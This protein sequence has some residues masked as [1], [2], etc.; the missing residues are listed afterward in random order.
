MY[1]KIFMRN[2]IYNKKCDKKFS[3]LLLYIF[4]CLFF[5]A[6]FTGCGSEANVQEQSKYQRFSEIYLDLFDTVTIIIGYAQS[7]EEFNYFSRNII[8]EELYRLHQLFDIFNEYPGINNMWSVNH[9]AGIQPVEVDPVIIE[10][11]KFSIEAYND[12]RGA[13][14]V[15]LGPVLD[16]WRTYIAAAADTEPSDTRPSVPDMDKLLLANEFTDIGNV[17]ID[18]ENS[19]VFLRYEGMS[20][21]V[22]GIAKGYAIELAAQKAISAGFESFILT[23]GGDVRAA[24]GPLGGTRDTWSV[25]VNNPDGGE[26]IDVI[27]VNNSSVFSSGDYLRYFM[28]DGVRYHHIIDP[29]TL[30]PTVGI[31]SVT[32]IHPDGRVADMLTTAAFVLNI[33]EAKE[34]LEGFGPEAIWVLE[35]GAVITTRSSF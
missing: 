26:L 23:V 24:N 7:Q 27:F 25:G 8:R 35:D 20:L 30:M 3:F 15:A 31:R 22:G 6:G 1:N 34:V 9:N 18:E 13:L 11:L 17:I 29:Y 19:T 5:Y 14:N 32:V 2:K 28:A 4:L 12:T 33:E 16:I 21:D 10:M